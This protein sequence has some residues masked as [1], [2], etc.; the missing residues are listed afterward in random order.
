[1]G[2]SY[3]GSIVKI[4]GVKSP[5]DV[6]PI[7]NTPADLDAIHEGNAVNFAFL[8]SPRNPNGNAITYSHISG[9]LPPGLTFYANGHMIGTAGFD[10]LSTY[11]FTLDASD[12]RVA[13]R[14]EF[15]QPVIDVSENTAP[16]WVTPAGTLGTFDESLLISP[17]TLEATDADDDELTFAISNG[18]LPG[19]LS[20]NSNGVIMGIMPTVGANT[21]YNFA[22]TVSDGT[23]EVE[24]SFSITARQVNQ[25]PVWVTNAGSLG[26][27][28]TNAPI[29]P[30]TLVAT[31]PD[32][33]TLTYAL[34][35]ST[36]LQTGLTLASN[37]MISGTPT[38]S[39]IANITVN[40]SDG[41]GGS[42]DRSFSLT[43]T[44]ATATTIKSGS[45]SGGS[46]NP[47]LLTFHGGGV[48]PGDLMVVWAFA[49]NNTADK[50]A[51]WTFD[52]NSSVQV[53]SKVLTQTDIDNSAANF[54]S[55]TQ[56]G[57]YWFMPWTIYRGPVSAVKRSFLSSNS[58]GA[59]PPA[60]TPDSRSVKI[61]VQ[62]NT[63]GNGY[64]IAGGTGFGTLVTKTG[65]GP[66][67]PNAYGLYDITPAN[68]SPS[69]FAVSSHGG[70]V[71][72]TTVE[73]LF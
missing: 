69:K 44:P 36:T 65:Y 32:S 35:N 24:R 21:T 73:L 39:S 13:A 5:K 14:R 41:L 20:L 2:L 56:T 60:L 70:T 8:A 27:F 1:M 12:G 42:S 57:D 40:V 67:G 58:Q 25:T 43:S 47:W 11:T 48:A 15:T 49:V 18:S 4:E 53:I 45:L 59:T 66:G 29:S 17:I 54:Y 50:F 26:V 22:A 68:W 19:T 38:V 62:V 46:G 72:F 30:V 51:G 7:W 23:D 71:W 3:Q 64:T 10:A 31:D 37:G 28:F 9:D 16:E 6:P 63:A 52:S 61:A 55:M 34:A 33:D